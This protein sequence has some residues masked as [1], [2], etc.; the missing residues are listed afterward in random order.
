M[1]VKLKGM[2]NLHATLARIEREAPA[3]VSAALQAEGE[4]LAAKSV[5]LAPV[6]LGNLEAAHTVTTKTH[7]T[8]A[9]TIIAVGGVVDGVDVDKY[10]L[11]MHEGSYKLGPKSAAKAASSGE[12]VGPKFLL[13]AFVERQKKM[14]ERLTAVLRAHFNRSPL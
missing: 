1:G 2:A 9:R 7:G 4:T 14:Q 6:D 10:S 11:Q 3:V 13:R 8:G 12:R 5:A